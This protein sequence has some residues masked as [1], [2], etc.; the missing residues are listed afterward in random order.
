MT[1]AQE[2]VLSGKSLEHLAGYRFL[3]CKPRGLWAQGLDIQSWAGMVKGFNH[4]KNNSQNY[5]HNTRAVL[6][7]DT[8]SYFTRKSYYQDPYREGKSREEGDNY[9]Q[10][11]S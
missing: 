4:A 1:D 2:D 11:D 3:Y 6:K 9:N 8:C 7:I 5:P 10:V